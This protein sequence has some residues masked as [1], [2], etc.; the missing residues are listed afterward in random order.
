MFTEYKHISY[1]VLHN[2]LKWFKNICIAAFTDLQR[3]SFVLLAEN[4][5]RHLITMIICVCVS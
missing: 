1:S 5:Y 3:T 2:W 4:I